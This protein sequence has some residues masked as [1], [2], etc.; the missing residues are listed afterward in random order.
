VRRVKAAAV[1]ESESDE[2]T[3][4]KPARVKAVRPR[5]PKEIPPTTPPTPVASNVHILKPPTNPQVQR[6][7][8][9]MDSRAASMPSTF[10]AAVPSMLYSHLQYYVAAKGLPVHYTVSHQGARAP[11][12]ALVDAVLKASNEQV[13]SVATAA[14]GL[15]RAPPKGSKK[16]A[17]VAAAAVAEPAPHDSPEAYAIDV[18]ELVAGNDSPAI[19]ARIR[20]TLAMLVKNGQMSQQEAADEETDIQRKANK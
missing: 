2:E 7:V 16:A 18:G 11:K 9:E 5:T 20:A 14:R 17:A 15:T 19:W 8:D 1:S 13:A 10:R 3:V 12:Q 4:V 6:I